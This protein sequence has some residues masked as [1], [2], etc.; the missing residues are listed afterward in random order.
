MARP[1]SLGMKSLIPLTRSSDAESSAP[2]TT[3]QPVRAPVMSNRPPSSQATELTTVDPRRAEAA[4]RAET[5]RGLALGFFCVALGVSP[6]QTATAEMLHRYLQVPMDGAP[7]AMDAAWQEQLFG[8][9]KFDLWIGRIREACVPIQAAGS[10]ACASVAMQRVFGGMADG[11]VAF[12]PILYELGARLDHIALCAAIDANLDLHSLERLGS[13]L[14]V[15]FLCNTLLMP[16]LRVEPQAFPEPR[17]SA[18]DIT[19]DLIEAFQTY[20]EVYQQWLMRISERQLDDARKDKLHRLLRTADL[21][22]W[23]DDNVTHLEGLGPRRQAFVEMANRCLAAP[24]ANSPMS[25]LLDCL[26]KVF[27]SYP[28]SLAQQVD[29]I[30]ERIDNADAGQDCSR[31]K[32]AL[33][34]QRADLQWQ[35]QLWSADVAY[36][37]RELVTIAQLDQSGKKYLVSQLNQLAL[38]E[39]R[40]RH[41]AINLRAVLAQARRQQATISELAEPDQ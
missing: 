22:E 9:G 37:R 1:E 18:D 40:P 32:E 33:A 30:R 28:Q 31:D 21:H 4:A 19:D 13:R 23:M 5:V 35:Y 29:Q 3:A 16:R 34:R 25:F 41:G 36:I 10:A 2:T 12:P 8:D 15:H 38:A 26:L 24:L 20:G 7:L 14:C 6:G 27:E 11:A 39:Y 17:P